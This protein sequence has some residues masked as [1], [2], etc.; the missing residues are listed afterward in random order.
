MAR[1]FG[2]RKPAP[3][4]AHRSFRFRLE[5]DRRNDPQYSPD[6]DAVRQCSA[7]LA[8]VRVSESVCRGGPIPA[9]GWPPV[10]LR[11]VPAEWGTH[12]AKQ[13]RLR[14][15]VAGGKSGVGRARRVRPEWTC[16]VGRLDGGGNFADASQQPGAG[17]RA[18]AWAELSLATAIQANTRR[19]QPCN[20]NRSTTLHTSAM[21]SC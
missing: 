15:N 4:P 18:S 5:L 14:C 11:P 9:R 12:I 17:L 13:C 7:Y 1:I 2:C 6:G 10:Y 3:A 16:Q 8:L 19:P 20:L 21:S